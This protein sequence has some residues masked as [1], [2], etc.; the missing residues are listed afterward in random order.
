MGLYFNPPQTLGLLAHADRA[1]VGELVRTRCTPARR[2][3]TIATCPGKPVASDGCPVDF[4]NP[5]SATPGG[6]PLAGYSR[7]GE[8]KITLPRTV[9]FPTGAAYSSFPEDNPS[10]R[11]YQ[12]NVSYQRQLAGRVL[13]D[14]TYTGNITRHILTGYAENPTVYIPG[15]C[16]AGQYALTADGPCSN[17]TTANRQARQI[18]TLLNPTMG[19]MFGGADPGLSR[20]L[21]PLQRVEVDAQQTH[22]QRLERVDQLHAQHVHEHGGA[23]HEL[24]Q[25]VSRSPR[26]IRLPTP[27]R[28]RCPTTDGARSI[29][30]HLFNLSSV[31]L[32]PGLPFGGRMVNLITK[33]WQVGFILV[34]RSGS[35]ITVGQ[36]NDNNLTNGIQRGADRAGCGSVSPGGSAR[37]GTGLR[38]LQHAHDVVQPQ[39][40]H[41]QPNGPTSAVTAAR[42]YG[43]SPRGYL[44]GSRDAGTPILAFSRI[45]R[46]GATRTV[47]LRVEAF[48]LFDTK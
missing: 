1:A 31:Y 12:F 20:W 23:G 3:R 33:D 13:V 19:P 39:C 25:P 5:W 46:L 40:V 48:N 28:I 34:T 22:G 8:P 26:S 41:G 16:V 30:Q 29:G 17:T 47:E 32:S 38:R 6:D 11:V 24:R 43:D 21:R 9:K 42:S 15:N 2:A 35:P 45:V 7:M 14:A 44:T 36:Q 18:L 37:L 4:A 10:Q 27:C